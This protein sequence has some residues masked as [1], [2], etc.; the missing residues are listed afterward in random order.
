MYEIAICDQDQTTCHQLETILI[1]YLKKQKLQVSITIFFSGKEL[2]SYIEKDLSFDIIYLEVST[3]KVD[4]VDIGKYIR[5]IKKDYATEIVYTSTILNCSYQLFESQPLYFIP[6]P[7]CIKDVYKTISL[8]LERSNRNPYIFKY[9]KA[10]SFY[11]LPYSGIIF[12]Q[13]NGRKINIHTIDSNDNFY[14]KINNLNLDFSSHVFLRINHSTIINYQHIIKQSYTEV[15]MS[16][17]HILSIS[18]AF[19][20]KIRSVILGTVAKG[21]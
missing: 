20:K 6:K 2:L 18:Q 1:D 3:L 14:G 8:A 17:N 12:F 10:K 5:S 15:V 4:G 9:Q 19:R 7:L 13:S 21:P 11:R 16:N